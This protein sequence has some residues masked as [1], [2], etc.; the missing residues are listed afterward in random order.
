MI[1]GNGPVPESAG[2]AIALAD[3]VIRFNDCHSFRPGERCDVVA[4][5]NTGRPARAML[6]EPAW[7]RHPAVMAAGE[8][9]GVRDPVFFEALRA[10]LALSHPELDDFC[11]DGTPGFAAFA[12]ASGKSFRVLDASLHHR[13]TAALAPFSPPSDYVVPSSGLMVIAAMLEDAPAAVIQLTGF[14]HQGWEGH[15]FAAEARLV[16]SWIAAGRLQRLGMK[17]TTRAAQA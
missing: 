12:A 3:R 4:V 9:W 14:T 6:Q 10:P 16:D 15:P 13:V 7:A 17:P 8:I 5:C 1:V 2:A 11:D